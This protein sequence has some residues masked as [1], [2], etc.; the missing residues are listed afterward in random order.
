MAV[1]DDIP[2]NGLTSRRLLLVSVPRTASNLLCK[3]GISGNK[4]S[5]HLPNRRAVKILNIRNQPRVHTN[6]LDGYFFFQAFAKVAREDFSKAPEDWSDADVQGVREGFETCMD[7]LE[8]YSAQA[9]KQNKMMFSKEHAFW[10]TNPAALQEAVHGRE[11]ADSFKKRFRVN[12]GAYGFSQSFSPSNPTILPDEYLRSWQI[13]FIIRHPALAWP[14]MYRAM[15]KVAAEGI[16]DEDGIKGASTTN[17][18]LHWTR[19]LYDW[20]MEQPDVPTPPPVIDAHDL[21]HHP[22]VVL[23]FCEQTG[24]DKTVVQFEWDQ[25]EVKK[26]EKWRGSDPNADATEQEMKGRAASIML[27]SIEGSK[28]VIKDK[29]PA[30]IDIAAETAKWKVGFGE[31]TAHIIEKAVWDSMPDYEYLKSKRITV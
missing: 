7:A 14:S 24:L 28:G 17:M 12:T 16:M 8:K 23:Q 15:I 31:E 19:M 25:N 13:A 27:S 30:N 3:L 20:C 1:T 18:N 22:E 11:V 6:Q 10:F 21:I 2:S 29:A 5:S 9:R 26:S 4:D